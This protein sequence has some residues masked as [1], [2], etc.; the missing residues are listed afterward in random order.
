MSKVPSHIQKAI[1]DKAKF[2]AKAYTADQVIRNWL[3]KLG[4]G[5]NDDFLDVLIDSTEQGNNL[6]ESCIKSFEKML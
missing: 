2:S 3:D 5:E 1:R 4:H 6:A